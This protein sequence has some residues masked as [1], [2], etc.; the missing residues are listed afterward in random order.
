VVEPVII[1]VAAYTKLKRHKFGKTNAVVGVRL[2]K[3]VPRHVAGGEGVLG[4]HRLFS[5]QLYGCVPVS[6]VLAA[7]TVPVLNEDAVLTAVQRCED[8]PWIYGVSSF[9]ST[10]PN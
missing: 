7:A 4:G 3:V 5:G 6:Q 2:P 9:T 8:W 10:P 1:G